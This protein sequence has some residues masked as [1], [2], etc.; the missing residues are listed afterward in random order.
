MSGKVITDTKMV[1]VKPT[2]LV[3]LLALFLGKLA[4][5]PF[6]DLLAFICKEKKEWMARKYFLDQNP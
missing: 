5:R 1:S 4:Q 6:Y 2:F 3:V